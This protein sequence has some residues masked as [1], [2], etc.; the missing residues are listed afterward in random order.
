MNETLTCMFDTRYFRLPFFARLATKIILVGF[1]AAVGFSALVLASNENGNVRAFGFLILIFIADTII[2]AIAGNQEITSR[3]VR[4]AH[5]GKAMR[6]NDFCSL[7]VIRCLDRAQ[8]RAEFANSPNISL[9]M[10]L[11]LLDSREIQNGMV[12]LG[13]DVR[14]LQKMIEQKARAATGVCQVDAVKG[15]GCEQ[16]RV[17]EIQ[18]TFENAFSQA[19]ALGDKTISFSALFAAIIMLR[20]SDLQDAVQRF[21]LSPEDFRNAIIF[22]RLVSGLGRTMRAKRA[23]AQGEIRPGSRVNRAWTSRPTTYL[24]SVSED[25]TEAARKEQ[26]GFLIGHKDEY[27]SMLTVLSR[28]TRNNVILV[29]D[30]DIGKS[31]IVDHLALAMVKDDVPEKLFDKRL[32]KLDVTKLVSGAQETGDV[33][34]RFKKIVAEVITA[35]NIVLYI[36]GIHAIE[37]LTHQGEISAF[38]ALEQL[39]STS[40]IP[41]VGDTT[42]KLYRQI[43]ETNQK[44]ASLFETVKVQELN[45]ELTTQFLI[46]EAYALESE[47]NITITYPAIRKIVEC[48]Y[49]YL[50]TKPLPRA[51]L[52]LL[53]EVLVGAHQYGERAIKPELVV[54]VVSR[55]TQIPIATATGAE[56]QTLLHLEDA[57]HEKLINQDQAVGLVASALRQYRAGL[58]RAKGPIASF[59]F[60]GPTGVGKTELSKVLAGLYFGSEDMMIRFD[61][62]EYQEQRSIVQFIGSP[63]GITPGV[64]IEAVK[65]KPFSLILLDEFEKAH[66]QLVDIFLPIFDEGKIMDNLGQIVDF[67]HTIII[68]TSNA[69]SA[70]I[71]EQIEQGKTVSDFADELKK[72]LVDYF[73]PEL[74]N[75]FDSVVAFRQL[76]QDEIKKIVELELGKL[77]RQIA[78]M[79]GITLSFGQGVSDYIAQLGYDPVFGARPMRG[80]IS[81]R[82]KDPIARQILQGKLGRNDAVQVIFENS[83]IVFQKA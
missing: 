21:G 76:T 80:V 51:S 18:T 6:V 35:G 45:Q 60:V 38:D 82:I 57:I 62:S 16:Q 34:E 47:W 17:N 78:T 13:V 10:L 15:L 53:Q 36:P 33:I 37:Q 55:K 49:M 54:S 69:H 59:L 75:R 27:Q 72:K 2:H 65:Q 58:A 39:F 56:A 22:G 24:D 4:M 5:T 9:F 67:K 50:H 74:L 61:M 70:Y 52:D 81:S 3:V 48:A 68:C 1:L 77:S 63:D 46:Y 79:Q 73:K 40:Q 8:N 19:I 7:A 25:M 11:E 83:E 43:I 26:A 42:P 20:R 41:V 29:G 30:E 66:P 64:L 71:K 32:V 14:E 23:K 31:A 44:F 28:P 12:R